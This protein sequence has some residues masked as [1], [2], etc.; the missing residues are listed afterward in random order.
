MGLS[1]ALLT[2]KKALTQTVKVPIGGSG[3]CKVS[4]C[5]LLGNG[6][7]SPNTNNYILWLATM[8]VRMYT[9]ASIGSKLCYNSSPTI[10]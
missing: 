8:I 7:Q 3:G 4:A 1:N 5:L 6:S 9:L 10:V 2:G